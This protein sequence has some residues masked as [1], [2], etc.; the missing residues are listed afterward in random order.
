[1][2]GD[3]CVNCINSGFVDSDGGMRAVI[4]RAYGGSVTSATT[5]FRVE[6]G[7]KN[8]AETQCATHH[9]LAT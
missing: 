8:N 7:C 3:E 6:R 1:M 2:G 4:E 9:P 5:G